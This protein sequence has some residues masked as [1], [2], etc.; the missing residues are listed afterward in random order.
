VGDE[1][2]VRAASPNMATKVADGARAAIT[3][4]SA[5]SFPRISLA[6]TRTAA[7]KAHLLPPRDDS[8]GLREG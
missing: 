7:G 8:T 6:L 1:D 5:A 2:K 3:D 4:A